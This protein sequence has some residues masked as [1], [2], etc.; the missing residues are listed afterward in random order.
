MQPLPILPSPPRPHPRAAAELPAALPRA[1]LREGEE[2][3][4][5]A[6]E[7]HLSAP[8]TQLPK[9]RK[10]GF[11]CCCVN[12]CPEVA[13][14]A[15][16]GN[17]PGGE[18]GKRTE[19]CGRARGGAAV[20]W[21]EQPSGDAGGS[22]AH[23]LGLR[24]ASRW[25]Q[26]RGPG[27]ARAG[28]ADEK[29]EPE[30]EP[31]R[32]G[33]GRRPP[34]REEADP[35]RARRARRLQPCKQVSVALAPRPRDALRRP[36]RP[37]WRPAWLLWGRRERGSHWPRSPRAAAA[38]LGPGGPRSPARGPRTRLGC[39]ARRRGVAARAAPRLS[40]SPLLTE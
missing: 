28:F 18:A 32:P 26:G 31:G 8:V 23:A 34:G 2:E 7:G 19:V 22:P 20:P 16:A 14:A 36:R 13:A 39:Q 30:E 33:A 12:V 25:G 27:R 37:S 21:P 15:A 4:G 38:T 35:F 3:S 5:R 17:K 1:P 40:P 11:A 6:E 29:E 10:N 24:L 9:S